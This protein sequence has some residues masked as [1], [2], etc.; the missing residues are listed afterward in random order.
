M[1][2]LRNLAN[3]FLSDGFLYQE[4]IF[5]IAWRNV[6]LYRLII[7]YSFFG[8]PSIMAYSFIFLFIWPSG[9]T[10]ERAEKPY[11]TIPNNNTLTATTWAW[12]T[13]AMKFQSFLIHCLLLR[14]NCY[15]VFINLKSFMKS[16]FLSQNVYQM[17][18]SVNITK[19]MA[20]SR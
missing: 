17:L 11:I 3:I 1:I 6:N 8:T 20:R 10:T 9:N 19:A 18:T 14:G 7:M 12:K 15:R 2:S 16:N 13:W 5:Q 4:N